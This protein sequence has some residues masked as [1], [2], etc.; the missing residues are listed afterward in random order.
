MKESSIDRTMISFSHCWGD[1]IHERSR[2]EG[3]KFDFSSISA[4]V[5][6]RILAK[7]IL[8][9]NKLKTSLVQSI[10]LLDKITF[11]RVN[12][13]LCRVSPRVCGDRDTRS[14]SCEY[15]PIRFV[16]IQMK[17]RLF[18]PYSL[19]SSQ[20]S[21][22]DGISWILALFVLFNEIMGNILFLTPLLVYKR[23]VLKKKNCKN[24]STNGRSNWYGKMSSFKFEKEKKKKEIL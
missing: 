20:V 16:L 13:R 17:S 21:N 4:S 7:E 11:V 18:P 10:R 5:S 14:S 12:K 19:S 1:A 9:E 22:F 3:K 6:R 8:I 23:H 24:N 15:D 2:I